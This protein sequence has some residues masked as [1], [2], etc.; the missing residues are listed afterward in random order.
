MLKNVIVWFCAML[1]PALGMSQGIIRE[2]VGSVA[3]SYSSDQFSFQSCAGQPFFTATAGSSI[4]RPGFI[5]PLTELR[6]FQETITLKLY[7]NPTT[8]SLNL[9]V[10]QELN[11]VSITIMD[12]LGNI[13]FER[14]YQ[15]MREDQ[16]DISTWPT[17]MYIVRI[18][19]ND[20]IL[21][22][23]KVVKVN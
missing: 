23:G 19:R 21:S 20:E 10:D 6:S 3:A 12:L 7:P 8:G 2:S 18:S 16:M 1:L 17:G 13:V 15:S 5:Q 22:V 4:Q 14:N 11:N 9:D